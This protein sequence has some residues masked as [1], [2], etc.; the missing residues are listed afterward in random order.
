VQRFAGRG[1]KL[2]GPTRI[3][4]IVRQRQHVGKQRRV[5][6]GKVFY[7]NVGSQERLDFTVLGPPVNEARSHCGNVPFGRSTRCRRRLPRLGTLSVALS[8]WGD[9]PCAAYRTPGSCS[10]SILILRMGLGSYCRITGTLCTTANFA[11][12]GRDGS[13]STEMVKA[14]A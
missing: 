6:V 9:T 8:R 14:Q 3:S 4:S 5:H 12:D 13:F 7:G 10:R 11:A 1:W 2:S